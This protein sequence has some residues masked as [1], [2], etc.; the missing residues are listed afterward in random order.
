MFLE[1][2]LNPI[3]IVAAHALISGALKPYIGT[4]RPRVVNA[5]YVI[6]PATV[7]LY[8]TF[9]VDG[10]A[11]RLFLE[12][13]NDRGQLQQI[14]RSWTR[15][16][17]RRIDTAMTAHW[18]VILFGPVLDGLF[19]LMLKGSEGKD[20]AYS[21]LKLFVAITYMAHWYLL[22]GTLGTRGLGVKIAEWYYVVVVLVILGSAAHDLITS[23]L[24]RY[25]LMNYLILIVNLWGCTY[26]IKSISR[27]KK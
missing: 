5:A 23:G 12:P 16:F 6:M 10:A 27:G 9:I 15:S 24:G 26:S 18:A 21:K 8:Q 7:Y 3:A 25:G 2:W 4:L 11:K 1:H 17:R 14:S 13:L 20:A 22:I 19:W